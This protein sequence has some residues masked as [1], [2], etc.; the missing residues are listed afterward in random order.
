VT[1]YQAFEPTVGGPLA[2]ASPG[3]AR[4]SFEKLMAELDGRLAQLA[5]LTGSAGVV[6]NLTVESV[7]A[8]ERWF[9]TTV[10]RDERN[11]QK[12]MPI[13]YSV[14]NDV[15]LYISEVAIR[16]I[17]GLGWQFNENSRAESFQRHVIGE[18]SQPGGAGWVWDVP[19]SVV[20]LGYEVI[21]G[22]RPQLPFFSTVLRDLE[23]HFGKA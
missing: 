1:G 4:S 20:S 18:V 22:K 17:A 19:M 13:W 2:Q 8:L 12:L 21:D 9:C 14:A 6:L 5:S 3:L 10:E 23:G 11:P 16:N 15:G 7:D